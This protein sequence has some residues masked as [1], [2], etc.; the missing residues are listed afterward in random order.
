MTV[1]EITRILLDDGWY[2]YKKGGTSH[3]QYKHPTKQGKVTISQHSGDIS[4][5]TLRSITKQAGF[6]SLFC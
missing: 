6:Q 2:L 4:P 3:F 5:G 1:R